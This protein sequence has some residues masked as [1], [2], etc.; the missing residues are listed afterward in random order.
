MGEINISISKRDVLIVLSILGVLNIGPT[1]YDIYSR[2]KD[3]KPSP[4]VEKLATDVAILSKVN[5]EALKLN[6]DVNESV[7]RHD[8]RLKTLEREVAEN[9]R[10]YEQLQDL[11]KAVQSKS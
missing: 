9:R 4:T 3:D 10:K 11:L 8:E 7:I 2:V 6:S 1:G 5:S